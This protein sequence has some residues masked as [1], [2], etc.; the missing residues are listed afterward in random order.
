MRKRG[1]AGSLRVPMI[2]LRSDPPAGNT[3]REAAPVRARRRTPNSMG[4]LGAPR[5]RDGAGGTPDRMAAFYAET[6]SYYAEIDFTAGAW[7]SDPCYRRILHELQNG[8]SRV[9]SR[10]RPRQCALDVSRSGFDVHGS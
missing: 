3:A 9:G 10:L 7:Q 6:R 4:V 8:R 5:E 1:G 2:P